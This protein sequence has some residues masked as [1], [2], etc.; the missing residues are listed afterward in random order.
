VA[1]ADLEIGHAIEQTRMV[2][3]PRQKLA[4]FSATV[5]QYY[6]PTE[7]AYGS[8]VEGTAPETVVQE[9]TARAQRPAIVTRWDLFDRYQDRFLAHVT[10]SH[11]LSTS[12][13][14]SLFRRFHSTTKDQ[15]PLSP[16]RT[17]WP[18]STT[19]HVPEVLTLG[20]P[21]RARA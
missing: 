16:H 5:L 3:Q 9:G 6:P 18:P 17:S 4:S 11:A 10:F 14:K 13:P 12:L 7:P 2:R 21:R 20:H 8:I 1:S 19:V 15:H